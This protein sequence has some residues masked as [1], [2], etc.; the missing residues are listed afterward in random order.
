MRILFLAPRFHTNQVDLVSKL[1][2]EGHEVSFI[3]MGRSNSEDHSL[4]VPFVVGPSWIGKIVNRLF[5]TNDDFA[6]MAHYAWPK[7]IR[8]YRALFAI[9]PDTVISRGFMEPYILFSLPYVLLRRCR[10]VVYTQG[11]KYR[12]RIPFRVCMFNFV[13]TR[14]LRFRWFTA[15]KYVGD[16]Q[17]AV[18]TL[19]N[20]QFIPFFKRIHPEARNR[21]YDT[22]HPRLLTVG[23][24]IERK[25][26]LL[27][28]RVVSR[29]R[30]SYPLS[31]TI[32]GECTNEEHR[33]NHK[34]VME[35][36]AAHGLA[37]CVTVHTNKSYR[38]VQDQ[39]LRHD[40]FLM[41]SVREPASVSQLEAMAHG[42]AV[43]CSNDN[44]TA[45]Y[46]A[47]GVNGV[48]VEPNEP[49]ILDAIAG[50][51]QSPQTIIEHGRRSMQLLDDTYNV[52][53]SYTKLMALLT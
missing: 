37:T 1:V 41:A 52:D 43:I 23:K 21:F 20:V 12:S 30:D 9:R 10:F 5:N 13:A 50:Y 47:H 27:L 19:S 49:A 48:V 44:G 33:A 51:C 6:L 31:L 2:G 11:P 3:V 45:H 17:H 34:E 18:E 32:I 14:L 4:I 16:P 15:V 40:I 28:L 22:E 26:F 53:E 7:L 39:Y 38:W 24:F 29:L 35:F 42:L 8:L 25:N 46:V 36:I